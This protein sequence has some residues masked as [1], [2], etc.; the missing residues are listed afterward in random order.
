MTFPVSALYNT[1]PQSYCPLS[2]Q[3]EN[4]YSLAVKGVEVGAGILRNQKSYKSMSV[5]DK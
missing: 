1:S 4:Y 2:L 3:K 5:L